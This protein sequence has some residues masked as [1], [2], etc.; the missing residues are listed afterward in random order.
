MATNLWDTLAEKIAGKGPASRM[1][2][3]IINLDLQR[4]VENYPNNTTR[5]FATKEAPRNVSHASERIRPM[6]AHV[7]TMLDAASQKTP[8][9]TH[10]PEHTR[11]LTPTHFSPH[12]SDESIASETSQYPRRRS[13]ISFSSLQ[14]PPR[15]NSIS[16]FPNEVQTSIRHWQSTPTSPV[17]RSFPSEDN[18]IRQSCL[19]PAVPLGPMIGGF[20]RYRR[21]AGAS[22]DW[23]E[24]NAVDKVGD[25]AGLYPEQYHAELSGSKTL[26]F[27]Q[28]RL[29]KDSTKSSSSGGL[30]FEIDPKN[31]HIIQRGF[32]RSEPNSFGARQDR[33]IQ[34]SLSYLSNG[35]ASAFDYEKTTAEKRLSNPILPATEEV[36]ENTIDEAEA[37]TLEQSHQPDGQ[38]ALIGSSENPGYH[39][40]K[41][42]RQERMKSM[43]AMQ[44]MHTVDASPKDKGHGF[45]LDMNPA[46]TDSAIDDND[47][48]E[49]EP[50]FPFAIPQPNENQ[51]MHIKPGDK[52]K[53]TVIPPVIK[54]STTGGSSKRTVSAPARRVPQRS[55]RRR[56]VREPLKDNPK[57]VRRTSAQ[58]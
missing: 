48:F 10:F 12:P 27:V 21:F 49:D 37:T 16:G 41:A 34:R 18:L 23:I 2:N 31:G 44:A 15:N 46:N 3:R 43:M 1:Q 30:E 26:E 22:Q 5:D 45:R 6:L 51:T 19:Y 9:A 28:R 57:L 36:D 13:N 58:H 14:L 56:S 53:S 33:Q 42:V 4:S 50:D 32:T 39:D 17:R 20:G 8:P 35:V 7:T 40:Y 29:S 11:A 55:L 25:L 24:S 54:R 52:K 47:E 38:L